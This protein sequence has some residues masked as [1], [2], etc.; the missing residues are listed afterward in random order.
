VR[1][2]MRVRRTEVAHWLKKICLL[3]K[4][5]KMKILIP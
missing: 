3:L 5:N 2:K 4:L 1:V